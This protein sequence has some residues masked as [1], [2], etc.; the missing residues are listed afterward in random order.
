MRQTLFLLTLLLATNSLLACLSASQNRLFPLG[1][2]TKGLCVV[3]T[4][5]GRSEYR[6]KGKEVSGLI[7]A[8]RGISFFK[9]YDQNY[10]EI[11][12]TVLDTIGLFKQQHY[13]SIISKTFMKGLALAKTYPDF[14]AATPTAITFCDYQESCSGAG[15]LIDTI[16]NKV[17]IELPNKNRYDL[18]V[19][20]DSTSI[21][22]NLLNY[23]SAYNDNKLSAKEFSGDL[24]INSVR[25]FQIGNKKLTVVHIGSGQTFNLVSGG[26]YPPGDEYQAKFA[27][28]DINNSVF[29]EPVLHHGN[30]FDFYIWE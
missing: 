17:R 12:S 7:P 3:E 22:T 5:L 25:Q 21:A 6:E 24:F 28:T 26:T 14:V 23:F 4:Q 27:F 9:I 29:E 20:F 11:F 19:L 18:K 13:D 30:G 1:Q 10:K 8:W 15:L 2:T 16:N